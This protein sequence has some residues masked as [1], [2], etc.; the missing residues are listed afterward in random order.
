MEVLK[1]TLFNTLRGLTL[2]QLDDNLRDLLTKVP[3]D[4]GVCLNSPALI[5]FAGMTNPR[6]GRISW[7]FKV[8][9]SRESER[10]ISDAKE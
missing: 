2:A 10:F 4:D 7:V 5:Q 1:H 8:S 9:L 3:G 6:Q